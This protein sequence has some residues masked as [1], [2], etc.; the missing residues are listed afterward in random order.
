[1]R[2]MCSGA[3][4]PPSRSRAPCPVP[5]PVDDLKKRKKKVSFAVQ[6]EEEEPSARK[7]P[8][9]AGARAVRPSPAATAPA[10][11]AASADVGSWSGRVALSQFHV[12]FF[13]FFGFQPVLVSNS[14]HAS[15]VN[16]QTMDSLISE[17]EEDDESSRGKRGT[18]GD[19]GRKA[20]EEVRLATADGCTAGVPVC[21][22]VHALRLFPFPLQPP[23]ARADYRPHRLQPLSAPGSGYTL[24]ATSEK[25]IAKLR[26]MQKNNYDEVRAT[27][28][29]ADA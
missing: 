22:V 14:S 4:L 18:K 28:T 19:K 6:L 11:S 21:A 26:S 29:P 8:P 13:R 9:M 15:H 7:S 25:G 12:I 16:V 27:P 10:A 24:E 23:S 5:P 17:L 3:G 20:V 1:M 2:G